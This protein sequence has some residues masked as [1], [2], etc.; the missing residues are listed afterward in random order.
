MQGT[1]K[2]TYKVPV[3]YE[4]TDFSGYVYHANFVKFFERA[5]EHIF[6]IKYLKEMYHKN[7]HF[8]VAKADLTFKRPATHGDTLIIKTTGTY[9]TSPIMDFIQEV[10]VEENPVDKP[11]VIGHIRLVSI[12]N[13]GKPIKVPD[14]VMLH[15]KKLEESYDDN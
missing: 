6:G 8:V 11:V 9:S 4:D 1:L 14:E 13:E 5:R 3:Y 2:G 12:D 7:F 15:L 10:Y